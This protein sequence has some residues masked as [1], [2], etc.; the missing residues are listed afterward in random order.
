MQ[1]YEQYPVSLTNSLSGKKE[2]FE[3][4]TSGFV[5]M[6]V[7]GP[8]VYNYVHLGNT[9]TFLSFDI[10]SRYLRFLVYKVR[11]VQNMTDVG[12]LESDAVEVEDKIVMKA[13]FEQLDPME[14]ETR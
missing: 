4:L 8:T 11:D 5:G 3:T 10:M 12:H 6:D 7:C 14:I 1:L 9:R 13:R 2:K